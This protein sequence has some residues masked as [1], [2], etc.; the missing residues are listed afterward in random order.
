M[1]ATVIALDLPAFETGE[2]DA[3]YNAWIRAELTRRLDREQ[4]TTPHEQVM[5][6]MDARIAKIAAERAAERQQE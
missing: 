2:Q 1:S 4:G 3:G 5:A 6:E